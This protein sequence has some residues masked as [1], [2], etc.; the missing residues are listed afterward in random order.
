[1]LVLRIFFWTGALF[2]LLVLSLI[3]KERFFGSYIVTPGSWQ[4]AEDSW[5]PSTTSTV[6]IFWSGKA[7]S[8]WFEP[9]GFLVRFRSSAGHNLT[10]CNML[11]D[12]HRVLLDQ[13]GLNASDNPTDSYDQR[14]EVIRPGVVYEVGQNSYMAGVNLDAIPQKIRLDCLEGHAEWLTGF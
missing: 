6:D 3:A 14:V 7:W 5:Q 10:S 13:L 8:T 11:F 12:R 2:C 9:N 1:M 4:V